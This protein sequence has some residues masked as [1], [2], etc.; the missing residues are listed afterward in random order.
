MATNV[1]VVQKV[2]DAGPRIALATGWLTADGNGGEYVNP[3]GPFG[4]V[5]FGASVAVKRGTT[6][7]LVL[8]LQHRATGGDSWTNVGDPVEFDNVVGKASVAVNGV[9]SRVRVNYDLTGASAKF[10]IAQA[11]IVVA[12][13]SLTPVELDSGT[14]DPAAI[15]AALVTLGLAIDI[16]E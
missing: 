4:T 6:P 8:Q 9:L 13:A 7:N 11:A 14:A 15:V 16:A 12:H 1:D 3:A 2:W 5:V 10:L